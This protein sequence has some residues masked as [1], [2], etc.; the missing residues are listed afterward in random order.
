MINKARLI[1]PPSNGTDRGTDSG[2][3]G[4]CIVLVAV[5]GIVVSVESTTCASELNTPVCICVRISG[6]VN[7][8]VQELHKKHTITKTHSSSSRSSRVTDNNESR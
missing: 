4:I 1:S 3:L 6:S 7:V 2:S 5:P 8:S